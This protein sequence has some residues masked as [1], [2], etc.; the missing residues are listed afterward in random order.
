MKC[1]YTKQM[2]NAKGLINDHLIIKHNPTMYTEIFKG[3][4]AY[5]LIP[6]GTSRERIKK[7][8][9]SLRLPLRRSIIQHYLAG[10]SGK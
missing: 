8:T 4:S 7:W 6:I 3:K 9:Q 10:L 1:K 5:S 2:L